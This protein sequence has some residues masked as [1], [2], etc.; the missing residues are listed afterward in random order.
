MEW[1]NKPA[2]PDDKI[3]VVDGTVNGVKGCLTPT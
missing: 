1:A 3:D 2:C